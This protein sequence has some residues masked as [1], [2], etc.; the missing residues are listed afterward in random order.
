MLIIFTQIRFDSLIYRIDR[1]Q[2]QFPCCK[3]RWSLLQ[4]QFAFNSPNISI[5]YKQVTNS[6]FYFVIP[7]ISCFQSILV[8]SNWM[9]WN[10]SQPRIVLEAFAVGLYLACLFVFWIILLFGKPTLFY[11]NVLRLVKRKY[12]FSSLS[13]KAVIRINNSFWVSESCY[14]LAPLYYACIDINWRWKEF[15]ISDQI[16]V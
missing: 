4:I 7:I 12:S 16:F 14:I 5:L 11:W 10:L 3:L 15:L 2:T 9:S 13:H 8:L 1:I 6:L